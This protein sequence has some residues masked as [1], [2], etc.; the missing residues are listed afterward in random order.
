MTWK[1]MTGHHRS[2]ALTVKCPIQNRPNS[3]FSVE[4]MKKNVRIPSKPP[5]FLKLGPTYSKNLTPLFSARKVSG[6]GKFGLWEQIKGKGK[7]KLSA[8]CNSFELKARTV[9]YSW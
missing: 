5:L 4:S 6:G 2:G 8:K 9:T 1:Y 7:M 3:S